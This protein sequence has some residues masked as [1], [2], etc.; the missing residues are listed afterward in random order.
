MAKTDYSN[1][2]A[3]FANHTVKTA[4]IEALD[5]AEIKYRDLTMAEGDEFS[6]RLIKGYGE[7]GQ[8]PEI[9]YNAA[10]EIKYEK[11]ALI[12]IDP[13]K[14]VEELKEIYAGRVDVIKVNAD[15]SQPL[16]KQLGVLGIPTTIVYRGGEEIGR[17]TGAMSRADLERMFEAALSE[18]PIKIPAMSRNS[19]LIRLFIALALFGMALTLDPGWLFLIFS[20]AILFLAV[21]DLIPGVTDLRD[22][23]IQKLL[24]AASEVD[25]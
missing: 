14:T 25:G 8:T 22:K 3:K 24:Q 18:G 9:D 7:D 10:N 11:A 20:G 1:A 5:G 2:F 15:E 23:V 19:R 4:K 6:K 17:R 16:V 13:P 12:L 21:Y